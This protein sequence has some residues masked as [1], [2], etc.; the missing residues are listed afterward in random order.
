MKDCYFSHG[1]VH[2]AAQLYREDNT[3][4]SVCI[5]ADLNQRIPKMY[6]LELDMANVKMEEAIIVPHGGHAARSEDGRRLVTVR[7]TD[8]SY[9]LN[10]TDPGFSG[11]DREDL[12]LAL[13][14]YL[15]TDCTI[16]TS[17]RTRSGLRVADTR[18][19]SHAENPKWLR[20]DIALDNARFGSSEDIRLEV[21]GK[22]PLLAMVAVISSAQ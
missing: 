6:G 15:D 9:R 19:F 17:Y 3:F 12:T 21:D 18:T 10:V 7:S 20:Y 1:L 11:G 13:E 2:S 5:L 8:G 14:F 4:E 16:E 22:P